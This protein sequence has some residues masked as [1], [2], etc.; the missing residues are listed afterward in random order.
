MATLNVT[1]ITE[2]GEA[3]AVGGGPVANITGVTMQNVSFTTTRG[4]S[5]NF[6]AAT[7]MVRLI[8][9]AACA[10]KIGDT[11]L[12]ATTDVYMAANTPEYFMVGPGTRVS[13]IAFA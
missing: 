2:T 13:A 7:R 1:E 3:R 8:A 12:A 9:D 10:V 6:Q 4:N 5:A 11:A